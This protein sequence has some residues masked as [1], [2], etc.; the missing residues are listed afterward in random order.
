[1]G[2]TMTAKVLIFSGGIASGKTTV[3]KAL[4]QK[5]GWPVVGLGDCIRREAEKKGL[6]TNRDYLQ[7]FGK[8]IVDESH[9]AFCQFILNNATELFNWKM[10]ESLIIEGVRHQEIVGM[11][12][13][14]VAPTNVILI[15]LDVDEEI[16]KRRL[17]ERSID[18][19]ELFTILE[20]HPNELQV[21][22]VLPL[23]ADLKIQGNQSVQ[24]IIDIIDAALHG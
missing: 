8:S 17:K 11:F 7:G 13:E 21:K 14:V 5:Y 4:S 19:Y 16:R 1:M 3:S 24:N 9:K 15:F 20:S 10:G 23:I 2:E 22:M 18:E 6:P 12:R